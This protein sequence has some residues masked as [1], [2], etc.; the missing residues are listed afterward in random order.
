M[1]DRLRL[2]VATPTR[3]VVSRETD[4]VVVPGVE[5]SFGVLPGHAPLLSLIGTGEVMYRIAREV[6]L[7]GPLRTLGEDGHVAKADL[8]EPT[9]HREMV[10]LAPGPVHHL[11]GP[12]EAQERRVPREDAE[13]SLHPGDRD[14][15][16][17][18]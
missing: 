17:L 7:L 3:L 11:A 12:D 16:G 4:E 10:L 5:G 13:R 9:A 14:L 18:A 6:D 2:E 1:A 15:V 8:G